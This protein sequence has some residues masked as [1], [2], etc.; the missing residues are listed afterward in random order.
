MVARD[1]CLTIMLSDFIFS[2]GP[3]VMNRRRHFIAR[4]FL[5]ALAALL[6][7]LLLGGSMGGAQRAV[8]R[9][10]ATDTSRSSAAQ[11]PETLV[12]RVYFRDNEERNRLAAELGAEEVPTFQGFLTVFGDRETYNG[13]LARGLRVEID[14]EQTKTANDP[15][16]WDTFY[17]GYKTVEEM[18]TFLDQ[19][20]AAYPT[21]A[22]KVDIGDSWCKT[23]PGQCTQPN[24]WN[25]FDLWVLHI[26]NSNIAGPKPVFWFD[27]GI[28]SREIATPELAM[29]YIN[30]LLDGYNTNPDSRWLVD[31]HD[32]WIMPM[33]NPDGHHMVENGEGSPRSQRKNAD[34]DDGCTIWPPPGIGTDLNRN[35]PFLWG[36]CGGSSGSACSETYR[37]PSAGSEEET[38]AVINKIRTLI[39]DQRGPNNTDPAPLTTTGIYQ[40]MHTVAQLNLYPWGWT[41]TDSP[42]HSDLNN[43]GA[44]MTALNSGEGGGNGYP[45]CQPGECLYNVDGDTIDWIYGELGAPGYTTELSGGSFYP[46]YTC[47]DNPGCQS[48]RGLWPENR[49]MLIY[50]AKIAR[51]PYLTTRGPDANTVATSPNP[52]PQGTTSRISGTINYS[53]SGNTY[54]QNVAAAEYYIDTPPWAG[55]AATAMTAVDGSFNSPTEAVEANI[56]T[57]GIPAGRHIVFVRGR[58]VNDYGG[59][60][61]WGPVSAAWLDVTD[62]NLTPTLPVP[63]STPTNTSTAVPPTVTGTAAP[64]T[65]TGTVTPIPCCGNIAIGILV[66]CNV[67]PNTGNSNIRAIV[68]FTNQCP[69]PVTVDMVLFLQVSTDNSTWTNFTQSPSR[70]VVV[71]PG[72]PPYSVQEFFNNQNIPPQ[73]NYFRVVGIVNEANFCREYFPGSQSQP[74]CRQSTTTVTVTPTRTGTPMV[75]ATPCPIQ[76]SD[77]PSTDTFYTSIRCLACQGIVSG[78]ADGTFRPNNQVTRGQLAK[79]VSNSAGFS[80]PVVTQTFEDVTA[81]NTFYE[82]IERLTTRGYMTGY[83]CGGPGEPCTTGKPYFRPYANATRGQTSKIVANAAGFNE[84]PVG[85]TFEDVP[86]T[87]TFYEF[88]QRLATRN[89]MQGYPCGGPGEPCLSGK[90][91]FRPGNDV[92][93]GQSSKI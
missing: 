25:G 2:G 45:Y 37:G 13:L 51:T 82:W 88:I 74:I 12:L 81:A 80:E 78:Y 56:D 22:E 38:Q 54:T 15:N 91:Y 65:V 30:W 36:C 55:G 35:F 60:Q 16:L 5:P 79:M 3:Q 67:D 39:P 19:K 32:I 70:S 18:E 6:P 86:S 43:I 47:I 33:L 63:S 59:F 41:D 49:G 69:T 26:T 84:P 76:F 23:H 17:G 11:K 71:P 20:V 72:P 44:H 53:W 29:R 73:Y 34:R 40:N 62:P 50:M 9:P 31:Y 66:D 7:M 24:T 1:L 46:Q 92:T 85:Q 90:P 75:T 64:P 58:G 48:T 83:L 8:A 14:E 21:L 77:V 27:A 61:S 89:V 4:F 68:E 87:H 57:T 52:V 28:H 42:N 93:R 10:I